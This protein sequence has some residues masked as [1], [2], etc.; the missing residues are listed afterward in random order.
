MPKKPF[1]KYKKHT[2][3]YKKQTRKYKKI[4][5]G[6]NP[7]EQLNSVKELLKKK[8]TSFNIGIN[9]S[10]EYAS[11]IV[12]MLMNSADDESKILVNDVEQVM[13]N[14]TNVSEVDNILKR[15][16]QLFP[17]PVLEDSEIMKKI[18]Q[19]YWGAGEGSGLF[20]LYNA[21][22]WSSACDQFNQSKELCN[23]AD[24]L[25]T[26][27]G[28]NEKR[29]KWKDELVRCKTM[30]GLVYGWSCSPEG[31]PR[32]LIQKTYNSLFHELTNDSI[33]TLF[34]K[35][36][37]FK[38]N[39]KPLLL[40]LNNISPV[41]KNRFIFLIWLKTRQEQLKKIVQ[42]IH[43]DIN[44]LTTQTMGEYEKI[45]SNIDSL[46]LN[47]MH[48]KNPGFADITVIKKPSV[49]LLPFGMNYLYEYPTWL[50]KYLI[51]FVFTQFIYMLDPGPT[52]STVTQADI[53]AHRSF[54]KGLV[55]RFAGTFTGIASGMFIGKNILGNKILKE[56]LG[57]HTMK[58]ITFIYNGRK[59]Q[60]YCRKIDGG[61]FMKKYELCVSKEFEKWGFN[62]S[63][64][65][66]WKER[67]INRQ[68]SLLLL[69]WIKISCY[70][71]KFLEEIGPTRSMSNSDALDKATLI[72]L[73]KYILK[74]L[75]EINGKVGVTQI[76]PPILTVIGRIQNRWLIDM[77]DSVST[78]R[79]PMVMD[80]ITKME[81]DGL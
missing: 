14:N 41:E 68:P 12:L 27:K 59:I 31:G 19:S 10:I 34:K 6:G 13:K 78:G 50:V 72:S 29:S 11:K 5:K 81:G 52:G 7:G 51:T 58:L 36:K 79:V 62:S 23:S 69:T 63:D 43:D 33:I 32:G 8:L 17:V 73:V 26:N 30:D 70:I 44:R 37:N 1:R 24:V 60:Q 4:Q 47:T 76:I 21:R 67:K 9:F 40:V 57:N 20:R 16:R 49:P 25:L 64:A 39:S 48:D 74:I 80:V 18:L 35:K 45:S 71:E 28:T 38:F 46:V 15:Y 53:N 2:R 61:L 54:V 75:K 55:G 65:K 42:R 56:A 3:K 22:N 66:C 77:R